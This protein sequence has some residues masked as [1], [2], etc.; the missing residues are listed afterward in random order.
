MKVEAP[1]RYEI[2]WISSGS[3]FENASVI[4]TSWSE[5]LRPS[6]PCVRLAEV[7]GDLPERR[8]GAGTTDGEWCPGHLVTVA[9]TLCHS[10]R[11]AVHHAHAA[12]G[13]YHVGN[14]RCTT[15][16]WTGI[17]FAQHDVQA[18]SACTLWTIMLAD[19]AQH[20]GQG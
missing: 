11:Y 5:A 16:D 6:S 14:M 20:R 15:P 9:D 7:R 18:P 1:M 2:I 10:G 19:P 3:F 4:C 13:A 17:P 8:S 12:R